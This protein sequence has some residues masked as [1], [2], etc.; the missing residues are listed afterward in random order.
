MTHKLI[1]L[2][3]DGV[4]PKEIQPEEGGALGRPDGWNNWRREGY[5]YCLSE[6]K[7]LAV[8]VDES[9]FMNTLNNNQDYEQI[10]HKTR[11]KIYQAIASN[12]KCFK[13]TKEN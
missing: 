10:P 12:P 13:L 8:E 5:N 6:V 11:Q 4:L 9:E 1:D 2:D 3:P 7:S